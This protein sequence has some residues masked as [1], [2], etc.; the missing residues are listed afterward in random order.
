MNGTTSHAEKGHHEGRRPGEREHCQGQQHQSPDVDASGADVAV[1]PVCDE[2]RR[3]Q[4]QSE[5]DC[6]EPFLR[7]AER[8]RRP[9]QRRDRADAG[10]RV[11]HRGRVE[12]RPPDVRVGRWTCQVLG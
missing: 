10:D 1:K 5:A 4:A 9:N 6:M 7:L 11:A 8:E 2:P 3:Q 12:V